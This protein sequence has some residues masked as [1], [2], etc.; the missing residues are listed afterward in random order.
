VPFASSCPWMQVPMSTAT[1]TIS[2]IYTTVN[3]HNYWQFVTAVTT[4][5]I[6]IASI[7]NSSKFN[8]G[9]K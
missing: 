4:V 5:I 9:Q 1:I 6:D 7:I 8:K 2:S 3:C